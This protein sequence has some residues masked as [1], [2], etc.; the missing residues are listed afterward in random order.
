MFKRKIPVLFLSVCAV[1]FFSFLGHF[2]AQSVYNSTQGLAELPIVMY[3]SVLK[4]TQLS[5]K[6][7]ITPTQL[8]KDIEYLYE[9]G[10][11]TVSMA[12]V[13]DYVENSAPL[14]EKPVM[15]TFDDGCYNNYGY[16]IPILDELD[17]HAVFS[18]VGKY[19]DSYSESGAANLT[20]GYMRW[21]DVR[22][23]MRNE[24]IEFANHSYDFHNNNA[25]RNGSKRNKGE[26][27][28]SYMAVFENDTAKMQERFKEETDFEPDIYCYPFGAYS[29]ES[30]DI[31]KKMGFKA[32]FSCNEGV[33]ILTHDSECLYLLKRFNRPSGISSE[34]FFKKLLHQ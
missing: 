19:T 34:E 29:P 20:Y 24:H 9:N 28:D 27:K 18:I 7:V 8:R 4:D 5:G 31:L 21:C 2:T 13:T 16:V 14:P 25:G 17:A 32:S 12:Q 30:F 3:H 10:Y 26:S 33:N 23:A 11:T 15:L 22:E 1:V 6:Y